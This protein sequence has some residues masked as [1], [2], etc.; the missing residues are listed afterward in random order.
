[1]HNFDWNKVTILKFS[2]KVAGDRC[3]EMCYKVSIILLAISVTCWQRGE[4]KS[5]WRDSKGL[6][7]DERFEVHLEEFLVSAA[8]TW[9]GKVGEG[10]KFKEEERMNTGMDVKKMHIKWLSS[11]KSP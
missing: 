1:M 3:T 8:L 5:A 6:R 9:K 10:N 4:I 2:H 7:E 11:N